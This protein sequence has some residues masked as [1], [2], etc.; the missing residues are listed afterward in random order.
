MVEDYQEYLHS[1]QWHE[2]RKLI[3]NRCNSICEECKSKPVVEIHHLTYERTGNELL[4]DLIGLCKDCHEKKHPDKLKYTTNHFRPI[5]EIALIVNVTPK[6]IYDLLQECN[7][8]I[9]K[10]ESFNVY[11]NKGTNLYWQPINKGLYNSKRST[12]RSYNWNVEFIHNLI[13]EHNITKNTTEKRNP[14]F[15]AVVPKGKIYNL[16]IEKYNL[17]TFYNNK[18][19]YWEIRK[20]NKTIASYNSIDKILLYRGVSY[21]IDSFELAVEKIVNG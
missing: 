15:R 11:T 5:E 4:E 8:I 14:L 21:N 6:Q 1:P 19:R 16:L 7:F 13:K 9:R 12:R 17:S 2:K 20:E 18:Q 3:L 10:Y